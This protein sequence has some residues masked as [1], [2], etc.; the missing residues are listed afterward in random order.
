[1]YAA[2]A[3]KADALM[4]LGSADAMDTDKTGLRP[5]HLAAMRGHSDCVKLLLSL[6]P[7]S[8]EAVEQHGRTPLIFAATGGWVATIELLLSKGA[9]IDAQSKDGKTALHWATAAHRLAA[10]SALLA[11]GASDEIRQVRM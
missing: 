11:A 6:D 2:F 5:I 9:P 8:V 3:G 4:A 7:G 10:M 1:M